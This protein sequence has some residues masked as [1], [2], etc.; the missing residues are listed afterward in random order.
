MHGDAVEERSTEERVVA[1]GVDEIQVSITIDIDRD[2]VTGASRC[3]RL[4]DLDGRLGKGPGR[5]GLLEEA[6][7]GVEHIAELSDGCEQV[8]VAVA[9]EVLVVSLARPPAAWTPLISRPSAS[10]WRR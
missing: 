10:F 8:E 5:L 9:I 2:N 3:G 6:E 1:V 4:A 7:L